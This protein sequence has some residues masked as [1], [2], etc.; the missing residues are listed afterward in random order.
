MSNASRRDFLKGAAVAG[1]GAAMGLSSLSERLF[2]G[3]DTPGFADQFCKCNETF[4]DWRPRKIAKFIADCGYKAVEIAPFTVS[5]FVTDVK[6][7]QRERIRRAY[8]DAGIEVAGLHWILSKTEGFHLTSPDKAVR[9][10]TSKY[11]C[12]LA[13]FCTDLGGDIMIFG[14]PKQRNLVEGVSMDQGM[15]WA[16][17]VLKETMPTMDR[18][19]VTIAMEPL[20]PKETNFLCDAADA[21]ELSKMVDSPNCKMMLDCKAMV[22]EKLSMPELIHECKDSMVHFHANDPN[23]RG[24]GMGDLD[25]VPLF[26]ALHEIDFKG[27]IS[28]EV[29]DYEPGAEALA[30]ESIEYM[31]KVE[32]QLAGARKS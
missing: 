32:A 21:V 16:A 23:L 27:W 25:F 29:F 1:A 26:K 17:D 31:R 28:V 11:L 2:G 13:Q 8:E 4:V 12:D 5:Q 22:H 20:G 9:K 3:E 10:A 6:Q 19:G 18:L 14:S 24:P 30:R 15:Q 7:G